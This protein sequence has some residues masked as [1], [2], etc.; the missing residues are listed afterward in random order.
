MHFPIANRFEL[1]YDWF[2]DQADLLKFQK[3]R[4]AAKSGHPACPLNLP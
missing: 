4:T 3:N 1:F 2:K